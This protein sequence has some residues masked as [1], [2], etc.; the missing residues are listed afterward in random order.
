MQ[1]PAPVV[2]FC[3][4]RKHVSLAVLLAAGG[5]IAIRKS[6]SFGPGEAENSVDAQIFGKRGPSGSRMQALGGVLAIAAQ[7]APDHGGNRLGRIARLWPPVG[8]AGSPDKAPEKFIIECNDQ[9]VA[10]RVALAAGAPEELAVDATR[11]VVFRQDDMQAAGARAPPDASWMSVPRPAML[12]A[13]V[14]RPG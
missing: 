4:V 14:T 7:R 11:L 6:L 1:W 2:T 8:A 5:R 9:L 10:A 3:V 13:T 12:V